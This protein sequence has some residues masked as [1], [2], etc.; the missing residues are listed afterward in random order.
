MLDLIG[1]AFMI[2]GALFVALSGIG[3]VRFPDV[4]SR[5]NAVTKAA[6]LGLVSMMLGVF[7]FMPGWGTGAVLALAIGL[8]LFTTPLGGFALGWAAI[9]QRSPIDPSVVF[10]DTDKLPR[11]SE[12]DIDAE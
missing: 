5:A 9:R 8:Q 11:K 4:Y 2:A 1:S 6:T 7:C 3:L 10:D 12:R